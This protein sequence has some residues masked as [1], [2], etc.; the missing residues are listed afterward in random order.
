VGLF[1]WIVAMR[2][3]VRLAMCGVVVVGFEFGLDWLRSR[4]N[5]LASVGLATSGRSMWKRRPSISLGLSGSEGAVGED[6]KA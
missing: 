4:A 6:R 2:M 1:R 5:W 3:S